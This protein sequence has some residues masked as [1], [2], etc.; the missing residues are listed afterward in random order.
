MAMKGTGVRYGSI[1]ITF[2]WAA[3]AAI[4]ALLILGFGSA[5]ANNPSRE[6]GLLRIHVVVGIAVLLLTGARAIWGFVDRRPDAIDGQ[7]CWQRHL[8]CATHLLLYVIPIIGGVS[9]IGLLIVS[10]AS[11]FLFLGQAGRVS[12]FTDFAP[13]KVHAMAAF[14]LMA[15]IG[16][17]AAAVL[18]H[19]YYQTP[20]LARMGL[21]T[22]RSEGS[23]AKTKV[24]APQ[25]QSS[26]PS[27]GF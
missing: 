18:F 24:F 20:L 5:Y 27:I 4:S 7:P 6:I 26:N 9:G 25:K 15:L 12:H 13:M 10:K 3:A 16:L 14:A 2:H 11:P 23:P 21:G 17:H 22:A 8:A 1:A 19:Q